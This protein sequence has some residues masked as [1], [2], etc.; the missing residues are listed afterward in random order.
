[1]E[2]IVYKGQ[3]YQVHEFT[4]EYP[5]VEPCCDCCFGKKINLGA[6]PHIVEGETKMVNESGCSCCKPKDFAACTA[7][8]R[9]DGR[10][11]FFSHFKKE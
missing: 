3:T 1:M 2:T 6:Y 5:H 7:V 11:V 10:N 9:K 4:N 8:N